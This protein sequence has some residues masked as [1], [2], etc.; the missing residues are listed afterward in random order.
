MGAD[1]F[2]SGVLP[3]GPIS[4]APIVDAQLLGWL[5][6]RLEDA[7]AHPVEW[8]VSY[9]DM[10][11]V[12]KALP[13]AWRR[14]SRRSVELTS[15]CFVLDGKKEV[16]QGGQLGQGSCGKPLRS[17]VRS[18]SASIVTMLTVYPSNSARHSVLGSLPRRGHVFLREPGHVMVA[19]AGEPVGALGLRLLAADIKDIMFPGELKRIFAQVVQAKQEGLAALEK[20]R[21]ETAALRNLANAA[22]AVADNPALLQL[23]MLQAVAGQPGSTLVVG[24]PGAM[25]VTARSER[26]SPGAP[27]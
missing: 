13:E 14:L 6:Q 5:E 15:V 3:A 4:S 26:E 25:P 24:V 11:F 1:P 27:E 21:G 17:S 16:L 10:P 19:I 2:V 9:F 20:A 23:R 12:R 7:D 18:A 22:R 8:G